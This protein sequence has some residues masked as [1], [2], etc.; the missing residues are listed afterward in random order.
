[1]PYCTIEEAWSNSL[2]AEELKPYM[3]SGAELSLS[4]VDHEP[5][6]K[7]AGTSRTYNR[8][9]S[10]SGPDTRLVEMPDVDSDESIFDIASEGSVGSMGDLEEYANNKKAVKKNTNLKNL[11]KE[12]QN[13]K[14]LIRKLKKSKESKNDNNK[15]FILFI[16]SGLVVIMILENLRKIYRK[17]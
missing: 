7:V 3:N 5:Y 17:F 16:F 12:N 9:P 14:N 8:L 15:E 1:M 13:L 10:H 6:T 11:I 2:T 4:G